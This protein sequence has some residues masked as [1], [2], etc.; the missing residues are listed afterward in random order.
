M[1]G[2]FKKSF[3]ICCVKDNF[4]KVNLLLSTFRLMRKNKTEQ[5]VQIYAGQRHAVMKTNAVAVTKS[6][7]M[8]L[9]QIPASVLKRLVKEMCE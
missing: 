7:I 6:K 1:L 2:F 4:L 3:V 9:I 8:N 5:H